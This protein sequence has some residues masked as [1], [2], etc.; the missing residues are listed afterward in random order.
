MVIELLEEWG[1]AWAAAEVDRVQAAIV[2][3]AAGDVDR[4]L[5]LVECAYADFRDVLMATGFAEADW[6]ARM[7]AEFG[8]Q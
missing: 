7:E 1:G 3:G 6:R 8:S 5:A 2:L 4:L